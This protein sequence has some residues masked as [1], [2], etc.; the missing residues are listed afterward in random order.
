VSEPLPDDVGRKPRRPREYVRAHPWQPTRTAVARPWHA[1]PT[2]VA[3]PPA[4]PARCPRTGSLTLGPRAA[5]KPRR[6]LASVRLSGA[7][8]RTC[9]LS[10]SR[11]LS[12]PGAP[13]EIPARSV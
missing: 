11:T 9:P 12:R 6:C 2:P 13:A 1:H 3:R 7:C 4:H 8:P 10:G 5:R